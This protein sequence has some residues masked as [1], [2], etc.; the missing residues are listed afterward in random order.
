MIEFEASQPVCLTLA[1]APRLDRLT[2][3]HQ[4]CVTSKDAF[5]KL[6]LHFDPVDQ[7]RHRHRCDADD[8]TMA[9][10]ATSSALLGALTGIG[11]ARARWT[12]SFC[13]VQKQRDCDDARH[14]HDLLPGQSSDLTFPV[15]VT[16]TTA[17]DFIVSFSP[18]VD[19]VTMPTIAGLGEEPRRRP[20]TAP[21]HGRQHSVQCNRMGVA[22]PLNGGNGS[23]S[24]TRR[25]PATE[26]NG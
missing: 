19:S 16:A 21:G 10:Y 22:H 5:E 6:P 15:D 13:R 1:S 26:P 24:G 7:P 2:V 8:H 4:R 18:G 14:L 3:T 23:A 20:H 25:S 12:G 11:S 9:M 17:L